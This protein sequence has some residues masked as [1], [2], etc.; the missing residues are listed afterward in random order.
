VPPI[1]KD[2]YSCCA[3]KVIAK[4]LMP[5]GSRGKIEVNTMRRSVMSANNVL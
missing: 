5:A 3:I 2:E 1:P 4:P